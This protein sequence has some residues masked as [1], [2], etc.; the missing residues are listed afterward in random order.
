MEVIIKEGEEAAHIHKRENL[1]EE[2]T[3][4]QFKEDF[5]I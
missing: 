2:V 4:F 5:L 3:K 1:M